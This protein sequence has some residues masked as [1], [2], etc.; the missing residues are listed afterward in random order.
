M[1]RKLPA[2]PIAGGTKDGSRLVRFDYWRTGYGA[3]LSEKLD[4]YLIQAGEFHT[5]PNYQ[6]GSFEVDEPTQLFYQISGDATLQGAGKKVS[7]EPGDLSIVPPGYPFTYDS[8]RGVRY[9]WLAIGGSWPRLLDPPELKIFSLGYDTKIETLFVE[10]REI[11][12]LREPGYP[13]QAIGAFYNLMA[14]VESMTQPDTWPESAYPEAVRNA[15][16][17]LRE[18]SYAPF[19][20]AKTAAAVGLS[21]SHL[22]ALFEK[23]LGESPRRFHMRCRIDLAKR[24][25]TEQRLSAVEVASHI[26]FADVHHFSRVFKQISGVS[27]SHYLRQR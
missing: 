20:A 24:L 8:R 12:I 11:L 18:N 3:S 13:L 26:G 1:V 5:K 4:F 15:I 10:I 14:R 17:F 22:R 16:V 2:R 7:L 21:Q 25:L 9:H 27:P 6:T 19:S 23:W